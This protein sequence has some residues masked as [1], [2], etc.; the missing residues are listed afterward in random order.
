ME[1]ERLRLRA[2]NAA[3]ERDEL[4]EGTAFVQVGVVEA[5]DHE[6]GDGREGISAQEVLGRSGGEVR[7]WILALDSAVLQVP[8]ATSAQHDPPV[9]LRAHEQPAHVRVLAESG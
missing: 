5:P 3:V 1:D 2:A 6:V 7:E 8:G 9:A 4:L